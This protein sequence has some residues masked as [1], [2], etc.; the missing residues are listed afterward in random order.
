MSKAPVLR[1]LNLHKSYGDRRAVAGISFEIASG[2]A[3]GLLGPNGA[4]KTTVISMVCGLIDPD[5]GSIEL[6][7]TPMQSRDRYVKQSIGYVPQEIALYPELSALVNLEFFGRLYGLRRR[8]LAA[9]VEE[10]LATVGLSGRSNDRV[11]SYS[12]GM[13]RR[14]NIAAALLHRPRLL[15]LDEPTVGVDP[16]SRHSIL[17]TLSDLKD[18]GTAVL[19][20]THNMQE[21]SE[22]CDRIGIVDAGKMIAE[23]TQRDLLE[24]LNGSRSVTLRGI[25]DLDKLAAHFQSIPGVEHVLVSRGAIDLVLNS[26]RDLVPSLVSTAVNSDIKIQ[27]VEVREPR[28]ENIFMALTGKELRD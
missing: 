22:L 6:C 23:G 20:T 11:A 24:K 26:T 14:L 3:Y 27:S 4:G 19:Y 8:L 7:E 1:C 15:V 21:A 2:E 13:K 25:G 9:R 18:H 16:Q 5:I 17:D 28:L 12:G 10:A